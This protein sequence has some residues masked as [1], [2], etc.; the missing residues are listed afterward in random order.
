MYA[1]QLRM[2]PFTAFA[3]TLMALLYIGQA[4]G[5]EC[6]PSAQGEEERAHDCRR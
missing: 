4:S 1:L 2:L 6:T 3:F 5:Y